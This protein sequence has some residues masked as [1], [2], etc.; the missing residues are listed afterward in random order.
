MENFIWGRRRTYIFGDGIESRPLSL[1]SFL[2][3]PSRPPRRSVSRISAVGTA[4]SNFANFLKL[5][6]FRGVGAAGG[7]GGGRKE[8]GLLDTL[9]S[10]PRV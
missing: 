5:G 8:G 7:D 6:N 9:N 3:S 2:S 10:L 4:A 1:A